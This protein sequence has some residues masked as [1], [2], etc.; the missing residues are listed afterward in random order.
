MENPS[1]VNTC[2]QLAASKEQPA[3]NATSFRLLNE[4]QAA[5]VAGV[6]PKTIRRLIETGRLKASD[7]G[8]GR[9]HNYRIHPDDLAL[10]E[11]G[12]PI[13]SEPPMLMPPDRSNRRRR[14]VSSAAAFLPRVV[15]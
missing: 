14:Q 12:T 3:S 15:A 8:T 11:R 6:S 4:K 7:F 5:D 13:P 10:V 2:I 1:E 9:H